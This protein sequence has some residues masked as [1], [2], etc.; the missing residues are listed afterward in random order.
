MANSGGDFA[1]LDQ[2]NTFTATQTVNAVLKAAG[3]ATNGAAPATPAVP[4]SG[5]AAANNTGA[6]VVVYITVG[7]ITQIAVNGVNTNKTDGTIYLRSGDTI[8][9]T[10]TVVPTWVWLPA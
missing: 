2:A 9:L 1:Q 6:N 8:T 5:V 3:V 10:Y 4:A 7:T